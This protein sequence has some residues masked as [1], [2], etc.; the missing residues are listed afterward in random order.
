M[1]YT[2]L[3]LTRNILK[4][5]FTDHLYKCI[6]TSDHSYVVYYIFTWNLCVYEII[7][8]FLIVF[9]HLYMYNKDVMSGIGHSY[10]VVVIS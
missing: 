1:D 8:Y 4:C 3:R 5:F 10:I 2:V 7:I 9:I 6:D